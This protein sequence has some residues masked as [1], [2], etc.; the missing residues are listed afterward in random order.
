MNL[1]LCIERLVDMELDGAKIYEEIGSSSPE[2]ISK[3]AS[4]FKNEEF[5]HAKLLED[6]GEEVES[7]SLPADFEK[8]YDEELSLRSSRYD[9]N[10]L[11]FLERKDFFMFALKGEKESIAIYEKIKEIFS[12]DAKVYNLMERLIKEEKNHMY[13]ILKILHDMK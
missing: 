4:T 11:N 5:N 1:L 9:K 8:F 10:E 3:V 6:M 7:I 2:E 13:F 12:L